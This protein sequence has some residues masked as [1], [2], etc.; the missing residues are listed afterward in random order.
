MS[1]IYLYAA[2]SIRLILRVININEQIN[3]TLTV[4]DTINTTRHMSRERPFED[5]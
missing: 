1:Y 2:A 5:S 3:G 4:K